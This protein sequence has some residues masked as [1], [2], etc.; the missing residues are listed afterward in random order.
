MKIITAGGDLRQKTAI[1][2]LAEK[3]F[4]IKEY[5]P[6]STEITHDDVLL[7]PT[8][9]TRDK[10]HL[11]AQSTA[12]PICIEEI[13]KVF[14]KAKLVIGG[15]YENRYVTDVLKRDDFA[16][17]NAVPTAE[18]AIKIAIEKTDYT[19]WGANVLVCGFGR[20]AKILISRLIGFCPN[21]Y[22]SARNNTAFSLLDSFGIKKIHTKDLCKNI[23]KFD[24]VF[25]T[26]DATLF[27]DEVLK[28]A[29][30]D[31]LFIELASGNIGFSQEFT[32]SN[33]IKFVP[34]PSLP[35]KIAPITA[36][37]ILAETVLNILRENHLYYD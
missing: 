25:N 1:K 29:K 9:V 5:R 19:L 30:K 26:A 14:P 20:V 21:L 7:L 10:I 22:V 12:E 34:A 13:K 15:N 33:Y 2:I 18:G 24:V 8:P 28:N 23:N 4:E 27:N 32:Q 36:G 11:T 31:S 3:G 17:F 35:G 16:Y 6:Y 37:K